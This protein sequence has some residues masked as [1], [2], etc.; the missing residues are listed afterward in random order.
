MQVY[1]SAATE[2]GGTRGFPAGVCPN[3]GVGGHFP[4]GGVGYLLRKYGLA[5]DHIIGVKMVS[6]LHWEAPF[7]S[8]CLEDLNTKGALSMDAG[9]DAFLVSN[10]QGWHALGGAHASWPICSG[11]G[12]MGS[13][14]D[15]FERPFPFINNTGPAAPDKDAPRNISAA[16][17]C[18]A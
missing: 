17:K 13:F 16:W 2:S 14:W 3:V 7:L 9:G 6:R 10:S 8:Y 18:L 12:A 15:L 5:C 1:Y 4:G 11:H